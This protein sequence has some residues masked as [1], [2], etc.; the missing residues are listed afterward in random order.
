M[1]YTDEEEGYPLVAT[2]NV[3]WLVD[4]CKIPD[5]FPYNRRE[6]TRFNELKRSKLKSRVEQESIKGIL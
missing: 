3:F 1:A 2:K 4:S 6:W 5:L